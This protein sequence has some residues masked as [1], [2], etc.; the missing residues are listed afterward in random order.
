MRDTYDVIV[1]GS[2]SAGMTAA[3]RASIGG[4]KVLVIEKTAYLGGTSAMSGGG[5]WMPGNHVARRHGIEDSAEDAITYLRAS[6]PD[7]WQATEDELWQAFAKAAPRVLSVIE[8]NT[9]L[10]FRLTPE[11]DPFSERPG[12][13]SNGRMLTPRVLSRRLLGKYSRRLRKSTLVHLFDYYEMVVHDPYHHPVRA[14]LQLLP[15][16]AWRW[17]TRSG[18]QGTALMVGLIKGCMD[19]GCEFTLG[20]RAKRLV[21]D[22]SGRV[23]G[24]VVNDGNN[25]VTASARKGVIIA[26]GGFEWNRNLLGKHFPGPIDRLGSPSSN[27]GDGQV[28]AAEAGALLDRMDQANI[29]PCLPTRYEGQ[30]HGLPITFQAEPHSIVVNRLGKR[31]VSENDF[32]IGEAMDERDPRSGAAIHLPVWLIGDTRFL[33]QS[34]PFHW[35]A[36]YQKD[37]IKKAETIEGL[38]KQIGLPPRDLRETVDR[39]NRFCDLGRDEDFDRGNSAWEDYKAHGDEN[40][41]KRLDKPPFVAMSLN[42][43]ILGTKGGAR[44]NA[45]GQVLRRDGSVIDGLYAAGLAM[46]NPIGTRAVGPGTT[47][48]PN[49]AWGFICAE[50]LLGRAD[51]TSST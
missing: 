4:L 51:P 6:S 33:R 10:R 50:S 36:S 32:N 48:G 43:S 29:Y 5:T 25:E 40:K 12:G 38:A 2:G 42:R 44:T 23:T 7:G 28:M 15:Q 9:P 3:L 46:A 21:Q 18:G 37:W 47:L 27:E 39:F 14:G 11:P 35:Y 19:A 41:L 30:P 45:S 1:L 8:E 26:T 22:G 31:F 20:T 24:V 17:I 34:I 49:M 16:L 13:K